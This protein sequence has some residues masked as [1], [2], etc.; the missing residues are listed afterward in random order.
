MKALLEPGGRN[1]ALAALAV[2]FA[3][4]LSDGLVTLYVLQNGIGTEM[5][6]LA[7]FVYGLGAVPF[8]IWKMGTVIVVSW[9]AWGLW[10]QRRMRVVVAIITVV[11]AVLAAYQYLSLAILW[12]YL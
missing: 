2:L 7:A 4:N 11:Y 1:Q 12:W 10:S 9:I 5:N 3:L 6:P 8:L